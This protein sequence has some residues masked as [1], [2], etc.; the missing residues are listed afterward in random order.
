M[1]QMAKTRAEAAVSYARQWGWPVFPCQ[2]KRPL[3]P[4]GF[5][6]ASTDEAVIRS[7]WRRTP[8]ANIGIRTG[9][10][11]QLVIL[12]ID[13]RHG[14]ELSAIEQRYGAIRTRLVRTGGGGWHLYFRCHHPY[15]KRPSIV[16]LPGSELLAAGAYAIAPPSCHAATGQRYVVCSHAQE[17]AA[18]PCW[19]AELLARPADTRSPAPCPQATLLPRDAERVAAYWLDH[20]LQM[21]APGRRNQDGFALACQLRDAG[22]LEGEAVPVLHAYARR[23]PGDGYTEREALRSLRSAFSHPRRRPA[24]SWFIR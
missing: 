5:L 19:L 2:G 16:G 15:R 9:Q 4:H 8:G 23:A 10:E 11:S 1:P 18:L 20:A 3:T 24:G 14:G 6:D 17:L 22:F 13:P 21:T 7:W 12:D